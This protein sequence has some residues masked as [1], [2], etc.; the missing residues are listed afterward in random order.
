MSSGRRPG[1]RARGVRSRVAAGRGAPARRQ[2]RLGRAPRSRR[3]AARAAR[4]TPAPRSRRSGLPGHRRARRDRRVGGPSPRPPRPDRAVARRMRR[5]TTPPT[6]GRAPVRAAPSR[7]CPGVAAPLRRRSV[8]ARSQSRTSKP[9]QPGGEA[10]RGACE[11]LGVVAA[12]GD[13]GRLDVRLAGA[14]ELAR[15]EPLLTGEQQQVAVVR[16]AGV[17]ELQGP[18]APAR[19]LLVGLHRGSRERGVL[20]RCRDRV[21]GDQG[22][23]PDQVVR[24]LGRLPTGADVRR[25]HELGRREVELASSGRREHLVHR[26][27]DQGVGELEPFAVLRHQPGVDELVDERGEVGG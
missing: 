2:A 18:V 23:G 27:A 9:E 16:R 13:A 11:Q 25:V 12:A 10:E 5:R 19:G 15:A 22:Q 14:L 6:T 3:P 20:G 4:R 7:P 8:C 21:H 1:R 24:T 17:D 26:V